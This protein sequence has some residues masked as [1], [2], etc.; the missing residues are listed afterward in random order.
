MKNLGFS[1]ESGC[2]VVLLV[3]TFQGLF[4][5]V[6]IA[7]KCFLTVIPVRNRIRYLDEDVVDLGTL[8]P[9]HQVIFSF[10]SN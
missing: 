7:K 9:C 4:H 5:D 1:R 8:I 10:Y 2:V 3:V 6:T